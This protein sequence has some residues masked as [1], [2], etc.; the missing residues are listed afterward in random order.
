DPHLTVEGKNAYNVRIRNFLFFLADRRIIPPIMLHGALP[1]YSAPKEH[2]V[3]ALTDEEVQGIRS[4]K[5]NDTTALVLR[6]TAMLLLGLR[7]GLRGAD[8]VNLRFE[9]ISWEDSTLRVM[10]IKTKVEVVLPIPL[11][12]GNAVYRYLTEGRPESKSPYI[13][14][15]HK[16]PY[17]RITRSVCGLAL[18]SALPER[19][20]PGSGFHVTRRTFSTAMLRRGKKISVIS[21]SLGHRNDS[22]IY[23]YLSLDEERMRLCPLSLSETELSMNG[24]TSH[25]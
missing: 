2:V 16:A 8:I 12:A 23:E 1:C 9:D 6:K 19:N 4:F 11:E 21:E 7:M 20:I 14:I 10:Q 13:F 5:D 24:G 15:N 22:T 3:V 17:D 18:K 25:V